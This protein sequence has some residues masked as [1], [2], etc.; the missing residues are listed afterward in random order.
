MGLFVSVPDHCLRFLKISKKGNI[1][2]AFKI[3][4]T[5]NF[6]DPRA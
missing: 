1:K 4:I 5:Q 2:L 6:L 3:H